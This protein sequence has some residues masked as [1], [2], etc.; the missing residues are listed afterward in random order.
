M[1][2]PRQQLSHSFGGPRMSYDLFVIGR[3][4]LCQKTSL[5]ATMALCSEEVTN[6]NLASRQF[7]RLPGGI[8]HYE[9]W[10]AYALALEET[11]IGQQ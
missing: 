4:P 3:I 8:S 1:I 11:K 6:S 9:S 7:S 2:W 10:P 5:I